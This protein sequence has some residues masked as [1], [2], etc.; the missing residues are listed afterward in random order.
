MLQTTQLIPPLRRRFWV[1]LLFLLTVLTI[2]YALAAASAISLPQIIR[3]RT[4]D[5]LWATAVFVLLCLI[6]PRW[7]TLKLAIV[8]LAI[9][10]AVEFSQRYHAPWIDS[11]RRYQLGSIIL[12]ATFFWL[13]LVAYIVGVS[14]GVLVDLLLESG[15]RWEK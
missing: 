1:Y 6:R 8:A 12:G 10:F 11:I 5:G 3:K 15:G 7:S 13:D 14:L 4:G 2:G 9:S